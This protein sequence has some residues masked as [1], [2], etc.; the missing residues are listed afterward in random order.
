MRVLRG[1]AASPGIARGPS[2]RFQ[3]H[4]LRFGRSPAQEPAEEWKRLLAGLAAGR[5]QIEG[6]AA[7][8][9]RQA[10]AE[11][12]AILRAQAL[13]LDDPDLLQ[14]ARVGIEQGG[15]S[16]EAALHD[17][18]ELYAKA[19]AGLADEYLRARAVDVRDA[20]DRV[21]R[22]LLGVAEAPAPEPA[23]PSILVAPDLTPSDTVALDKS[24]ILGFCTAEGG[25]TSHTAILAK[26]LGLPAVVGLGPELLHIADGTELVVDGGAGVLLVQP[27]EETADQLGTKG[28]AMAA[29]LRRARQRAHEPAITRD[30]HRV[31][32]AANIGEVE[33]AKA[34]LAEGAEGVGLLRSE[35]LYLGRQHLPDEEEQYRAYRAILDI[36]DP[37]PVI[38]RTLDIG[39]D[40]ELPYIELARE[41]NP[42]LGVRGT[43]LGLARPELLIPQ[44]R[45]ALRSGAGRNFRLMLP[46][47][48]TA[49]EVRRVRALL[50]QSRADLAAAGLPAGDDLPVGIMVE[51]PAAALM[52]DR[53]VH[54]ADFMS[55]GTNDLAQYT[56]AADRT[57]P[58]LAPLANALNPAVLRLIERIVAASRAAGRWVGVCGE[59]GGDPL[60][61]PILVGLGIDELSMAPPAIPVAKDLIRSL[62]RA[63]AQALAGRALQLESAEQVADFVASE[64][65][66]ARP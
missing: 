34:A 29:R 18:A 53:L 27:D 52:A 32:I 31:E 12:A 26:A 3:K 20:A 9:E 64:V 61:I 60:A 22:V 42:F 40:K 62:S 2:L 7:Q 30:G 38:L 44:L 25:P 51:T 1:I 48:A 54:V 55:I 28:E 8:V 5:R 15:L 11:Q 45:A 33:E 4:E 49:E 39:G 43:R 46:M 50:E 57:N 17:A 59:M 14:Q 13:M 21:L 19:L 16:A 63:E 58:L 65:P 66:A 37:R 24:L 10:G 23:V 41:A 6:F 56:M 47:V 35:F 36:L